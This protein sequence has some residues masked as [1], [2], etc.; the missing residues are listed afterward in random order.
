[1]PTIRYLFESQ[2][3]LFI[4]SISDELYAIGC[5]EDTTRSDYYPLPETVYGDATGH[6]AYD[7]ASNK[8][9]VGI[10]PRFYSSTETNAT[11]KIYSTKLDGG[12]ETS[13]EIPYTLVAEAQGQAVGGEAMEYDPSTQSYATLGASSFI[14]ED[15]DNCV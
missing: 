4:G 7:P 12:K 3:I 10:Y 5:E 1:V 9:Y 13:D 2:T 11:L 8:V 6:L 15:A 14:N